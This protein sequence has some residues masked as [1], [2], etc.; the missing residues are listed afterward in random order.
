MTWTYDHTCTLA[1]PP[2]RVYCAW[3]DPTE[4]TR[5]F[6]ERVD[7]SVAPG[8]RYRFWGRHTLGSPAEPEA[9]QSITRLEPGRTLGFSWR[10]YGVDTEVTVSLTADE[11][12]SKLA[13][14]HRIDG[15]LGVS[16][17]RELIDD[18]W[19]L[20]CGNLAKHLEGGAGI[21]LP[22]YSDPTPEVR[23]KVSIA[24]PPEAVFRAL[25]EPAAINK[26]FG[27]ESAVVEPR[28]GGRYA[29]NWSYKV[30]GK[31]VTGGPTRILEIISN[32][33]LVLDWPDWR[34]DAS[35]TGQS[36]VFLLEP[37]GTGTR[38]TF[39]HAGFGR[40]TDISDYP[41]GWAWFLDGLKREAE[42][43]AA[44]H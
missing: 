43:L 27:S 29:L 5:W 23:L 40:T 24:A 17:A 30:D 19:R 10:L 21:M 20:T 18:L 41:F 26:W 16:R 6:A 12:G 39:V 2:E 44:S 11:K 15:D 9:R 3:T 13:L 7:L 42:A 33:K 22:D 28:V 4:L 14:S 34:G 25:I 31:E 1:A 38:L 32:R 36:I 37:E 35:V 8:G